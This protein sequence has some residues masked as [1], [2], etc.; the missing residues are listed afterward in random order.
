MKI[1]SVMFD[2]SGMSEPA[3]HPEISYFRQGAPTSESGM[4]CFTAPIGRKGDSITLWFQPHHLKKLLKY[5]KEAY[6]GYLEDE[7]KS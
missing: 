7:Q 4:A 5:T 1:N 3:K 6:K 2:I